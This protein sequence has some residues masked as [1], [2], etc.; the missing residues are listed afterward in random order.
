M[1][2]GQSDLDL[3]SPKL[4]YIIALHLE[5]WSPCI[6]PALPWFLGRN[7]E[8]VEGFRMPCSYYLCLLRRVSVLA[9]ID[10]IPHDRKDGF[11]R[12]LLSLPASQVSLADLSTRSNME[13]LNMSNCATAD[14]DMDVRPELEDD[15]GH[16][17][18]KA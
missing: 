17:Y 6:M 7:L 11:Y 15:H 3:S 2:R 8:Y 5:G 4:A 14:D 13:L 16:S 10:G 9:K 12:C 1:H 18:I